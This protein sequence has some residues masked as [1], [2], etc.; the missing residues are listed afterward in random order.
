[1]TPTEIVFS[2]GFTSPDTGYVDHWTFTANRLTGEGKLKVEKG[3][4]GEGEFK[5]SCSKAAPRF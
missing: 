5:Y 3:Q 4:P 2:G 1:M